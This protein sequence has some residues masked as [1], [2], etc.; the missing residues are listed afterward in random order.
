MSDKGGGAKTQDVIQNRE[1][2]VF[3]E[4]ADALKINTV[5]PQTA[6]ANLIGG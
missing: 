6:T 4:T 5:T 3:T 2:M 1:W